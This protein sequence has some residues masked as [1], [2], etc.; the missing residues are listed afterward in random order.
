M[1]ARS[2]KIPVVSFFDPDN[3]INEKSLGISPSNIEEMK[4]RIGGLLDDSEKRAA[5]GKAGYE[6]VV[7]N[8]SPNAV[9]TEYDRVI[10]SFNTGSLN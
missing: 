4:Q 9:V 1:Q 7:S 8:Y 10:T 5:M 3:L 6:F 2:H